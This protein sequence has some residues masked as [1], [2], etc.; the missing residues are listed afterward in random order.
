MSTRVSPSFLAQELVAL[1]KAGRYAD[2]VQAFEAARLAGSPSANVYTAVTAMTAAT[3]LGDSAFAETA[4]A[5]LQATGQAHSPYAWTA[6]LRARKSDWRA[7]L[8]GL[9]AMR[10]AGV[11]I[12]G[13]AVTAV[14]A[15]CCAGGAEGCAAAVPLF[16]DSLLDALDDVDSHLCA[17]FIT[18]FGRLRD[19]TAVRRVWAWAAE[20]GCE[21]DSHLFCAF[22]AALL[23]A[24]D[25]RHAARVFQTSP[26]PA[27]AHCYATGMRALSA[28]GVPSAVAATEAAFA[29]ML[30]AGVTPTKHCHAALLGCYARAGQADAA[31]GALDDALAGC[32]G[33]EPPPAVCTHLAMAACARVGRLADAMH[34]LD[35]LQQAGAADVCSYSTAMLAAAVAGSPETGEQVF[36]AM[37][38][39]RVVPNDYTFTALISAHGAAARTATTAAEA[40]ACA[41]AARGVRDRMKAYG[42][43]P[44]IHVF[45]ACLSACE[46]ARDDS[47]A[48]VVYQELVDQG[49]AP[50]QATRRLMA[51]VGKRGVDSVN[52]AQSSLTAISA[53]GAALLATLINRGFL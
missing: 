22:M 11:C 31:L 36:A 28:A 41:R 50:N 24:G 26:T 18:L 53:L 33:L 40:L 39:A 1:S 32:G 7:A 14:L 30:A 16:D 44:S 49:V 9:G 34:L 29:R 5:W 46:A 52:A 47:A 17:A 23:R 27:S 25:A 45:N 21:V 12:T 3:R 15:A 6:L 48:L 4:F 51:I 10:A 43:V 20:R 37:A 42:L 38:R 19:A 2:A 13:H 35:R 8:D